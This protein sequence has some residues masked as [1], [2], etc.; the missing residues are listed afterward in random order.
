MSVRLNR[1]A[2]TVREVLGNLITTKLKDPR[3]GMA[4]VTD[5]EIASD[6]KTAKVYMSILGSDEEKEASLKALEAAKGYLKSELARAV[7]MK[8]TPDLEFRIDPSIEQGIRIEELIRTLKH[9]EKEED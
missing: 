9:E 7:R 8:S 5:V 3:I 2:E 1:V 6:L 4:T